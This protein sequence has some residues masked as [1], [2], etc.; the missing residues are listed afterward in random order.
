MTSRRNEAEPTPDEAMFEGD[1]N[2]AGVHEPSAPDINVQFRFFLGLGAFS[3]VVAA[4]YWFTSYEDAGTTMLALAAGLALLSG[5]YLWV[6]G[7]TLATPAGEGADAPDHEDD[8][9][10]SPH[11]SIWPF[12]VGLA[13]YFVT[14]GLILGIWFLVPGIVLMATA[15]LGY[16]MQSRR[17]D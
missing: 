16:S 9:H 7:R 11:A 4:V 12:A 8:D 1:S 5:A 10:Y 6:Q 3:A 17:R 13:A 2:E 15:V 14:N